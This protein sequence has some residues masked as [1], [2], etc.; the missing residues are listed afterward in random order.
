VFELRASG[1]LLRYRFL[2][3]FAVRLCGLPALALMLIFFDSHLWARVFC[4]ATAIGL[5]LAGRYLF[6]VSVVPKNMA[7][8]YLR[9]RR[10][11]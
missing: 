2:S 1:E 7:A 9:E 3:I 8:P 4:L 5:E 6:F 10:A 11:A